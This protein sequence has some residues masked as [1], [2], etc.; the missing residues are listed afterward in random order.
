MIYWF[1]YWIYSDYVT[2]NRDYETRELNIDVNNDWTDEYF[3][4]GPDSPN[5]S[6]MLWV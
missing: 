6:I 2:L 3:K 4:I 1:Y 5:W